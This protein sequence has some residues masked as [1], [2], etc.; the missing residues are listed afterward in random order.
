[1]DIDT[2]QVQMMPLIVDP[3]FSQDARPQYKY[4]E[5]DVL[6]F[7]FR[8]DPDAIRAVLPDCYQVGAP[9]TVTVVFGD[10]DG[11]DFMAGG[12]YRTATFQVAARFDGTTDHVEGDHVLV[13]LEDKTMPI[14][15]GREV[16]GVPKMF[17]DISPVK[18]LPT[19]AR[20]MPVIRR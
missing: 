15:S 1:M 5:I 7:Q 10:Y 11:V 3:L 6:A 8:T 19:P 20:P 14:I 16:I 18:T 13:M 4:S 17:A 9:P 2:D 12:G